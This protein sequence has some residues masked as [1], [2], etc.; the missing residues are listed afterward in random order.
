MPF[1]SNPLPS[2]VAEALNRGNM[3]EAIR[4]L[5]DA[6]G[7]S[8][9]DARDALGEY[10]RGVSSNSSRITSTTSS[11]VQP[12]RPLH[13]AQPGNKAEVQ[14]FIRD[15]PFDIGVSG[16]S[17]VGKA[18]S[19]SNAAEVRPVNAPTWEGGSPGEMPKSSGGIWWVVAAI[20]IAAWFYFRSRPVWV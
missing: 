7:V 14:K 20:A 5:R 1:P 15:H 17:S 12:P 11:T 2:Q 8:L 6:K 4:L 19:S 3:I 9:K 18:V 10:V 13:P 16:G